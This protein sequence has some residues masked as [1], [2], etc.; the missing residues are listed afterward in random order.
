MTSVPVAAAEERGEG[1]AARTLGE[2]RERSAWLFLVPMLVLMAVVAGWPLARTLW[3]SV[4]DADLKDLGAAKFVGL[5]NYVG[6]YGVL[7][8]PDWWRAVGNTLWFAAVSVAL[9]T[10][11]GTAVALVLNADFPGR[12][13]VRAAVLVPWAIPTVVSAKM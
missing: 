12:G 13:V 1:R 10:A 2:S 6:E 8:D 11:L 3:F 7:Q 5:D 4:T 9:E